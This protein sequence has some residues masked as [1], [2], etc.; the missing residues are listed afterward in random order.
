MLK[1]NIFHIWSTLAGLGESTKGIFGS[2]NDKVIFKILPTIFNHFLSRDNSRYDTERSL[3]MKIVGYS[4]KL[5][6]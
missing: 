1:A 3:L 4:P 5:Q 6:Y 2:G